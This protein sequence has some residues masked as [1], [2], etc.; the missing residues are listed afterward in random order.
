MFEKNDKKIWSVLKLVVILH[1]FSP[2]M[3]RKS[4]SKKSSLTCL[5]RCN[6]VQ[7]KGNFYVPVDSDTWYTIMQESSRV[8]QTISVKCCVF[9]LILV[10]EKNDNT[11]TKSLILAQ[12]ER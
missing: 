3:G 2:Q 9:I 7:E 4:D 5:Q 12:D 6:V 8:G 1:R 10:K 11:T